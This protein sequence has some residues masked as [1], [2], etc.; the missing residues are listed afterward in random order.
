MPRVEAVTHPEALNWH[1]VYHGFGREAKPSEAALGAKRTIKITVEKEQVF[2]VHQRGSSLRQWCGRC[3]SEATMLEVEEAAAIAHATPRAVHRWVQTE[4][5]HHA[6]TPEGLVL[7][8]LNSL[9][10]LMT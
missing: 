10:Q 6:Q 2:I 3:S 7:I 8:C 9:L 5:L 4:R 1:P